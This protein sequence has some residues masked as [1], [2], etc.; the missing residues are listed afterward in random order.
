MFR[1]YYLAFLQLTDSR[2]WKPVLWAITLSLVAILL[3]III[4]GAFLYQAFDSLTNN[5]AGWMSWADGWIEGLGVILGTLLLGM[6][7]YFFLASVYA[8]F[9]GIFLDGALNAVKEVH[10]PNANWINPPGMIES[11]ISSLRFI[12]W[13]MVV[14]LIAS[15]IL[16]IGYLIPPLGLVL[17]LFLSGYLL[18][19][20]YG[21]LV[22]M[23]LPNE[24]RRKK[25]GSLMHGTFATFLWAFPPINFIAPLLL[26]ASLVHHRLSEERQESAQFRQPN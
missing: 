25:T 15:P 14:Y 12:L 3:C 8:A 13:S 5:L 6:L 16:I 18:N 21:Q 23:R 10:Y 2:L 20:E 1:D 9:L 24:Q 26:G 19:K 22:E 17:Q 7:G 4:G 11:T